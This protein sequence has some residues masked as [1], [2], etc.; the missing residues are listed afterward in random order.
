MK[1]V[2]RCEGCGYAPDG[3]IENDIYCQGFCMP[4]HDMI[5]LDVMPIFTKTPEERK[6]ELCPEHLK[7]YMEMYNRYLSYDG[8]NECRS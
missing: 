7:E 1:E 4:C 5:G 2:V 6:N 8:W 3:T